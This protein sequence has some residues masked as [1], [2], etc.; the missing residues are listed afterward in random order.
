MQFL[1]VKEFSSK[2]RQTSEILKKNGEIVLTKNGKPSM[3]VMDIADRDF[4][5][6]TDML[7]RMEGLALLEQVRNTAMEKGGNDLSMDQINT[8]IDAYRREKHARI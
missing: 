2:P 6:I 3:L 4:M 5:L 7:R 1:T 8:E